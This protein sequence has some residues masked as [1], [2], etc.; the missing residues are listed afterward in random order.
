MPVITAE[1]DIPRKIR[2][3]RDTLYIIGSGTIALG[4]WNAVRIFLMV[5]N[6][7]QILITPRLTEVINGVPG[8]IVLFLVTAAVVGVLLSIYLFVG[9]KAREEGLG[10]KKHSF[11]I[12]FIVLLILFHAVG[13]ISSGIAFFGSIGEPEE[14]NLSHP[15]SV[16]VDVT[17]AVTL[18]EMLV[19]AVKI[20]VYERNGVG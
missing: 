17:A 16:I 7:P 13:A 19:S 20:R 10:R 11:Y 8:I 4:I 12:A 15:V 3:Y 14:V 18:A 5:L 1:N 2:K 9:R 6:S